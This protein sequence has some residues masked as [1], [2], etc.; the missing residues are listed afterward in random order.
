MT[1][2]S[3]GAPPPLARRA[4]Q[5]QSGAQGVAPSFT[6][7]EILVVL[8]IIALLAGILLPAIVRSRDRARRTHCQNN[9]SQVTR[10]LSLYLNDFSEYY[11]S[12][13]NYGG[14]TSTGANTPAVSRAGSRVTCEYSNFNNYPITA[15]RHMVM[16]YASGHPA[17]YYTP[18]QLNFIP[19]GLGLLITRGYFQDSASLSCPVLSSPTVTWYGQGTS[20]VLYGFTYYGPA[21]WS[22]LGQATPSKALIYGDG[23]WLPVFGADQCLALLTG[24]SYRLTP[25]F[26]GVSGWTDN[27]TLRPYV[28]LPYAKPAVKAYKMCPPFKTA[29]LLGQR[30]IVSDTFDHAA[31]WQGPTM[32]RMHHGE[33]YNTLYADGH[34]A[35]RFDPDDE[36]NTGIYLP[37]ARYDNLTS[38]SPTSQEAWHIFD[39]ANGVDE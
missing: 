30:A 13:V 9:L 36:M 23:R 28:L 10:A 20:S 14:L 16:A 5:T 25:Y 3:S 8:A 39:L 24:Y 4:Q 22:R 37:S 34:A 1:W 19:N 27:S 35:W 38:S 15:P 33:G 31:T 12:Y 6:L 32:V 17:S 11:P 29:K 2:T 7:V 21:T 26:R 18:G